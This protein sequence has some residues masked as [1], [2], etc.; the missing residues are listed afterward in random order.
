MSCCVAC[1][2]VDRRGGQSP[3]RTF[4]SQELEHGISV[5]GGRSVASKAFMPALAALLADTSA[6]QLKIVENL[7]TRWTSFLPGSGRG[8]ELRW[9]EV[10]LFSN[11]LKMF[12]ESFY[13]LPSL[14]ASTGGK[15]AISVSDMGDGF[16]PSY[17]LGRFGVEIQ[18]PQCFGS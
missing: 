18:A 16:H 14:Y 12:L 10:A 9:W 6:V 4:I 11:G 13:F 5:T 7:M 17:R 8:L 15:F 1:G 2:F 3:T